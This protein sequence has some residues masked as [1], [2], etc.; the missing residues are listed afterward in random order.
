MERRALLRFPPT[1]ALAV[2]SGEGAEEYAAT[3]HAWRP[4]AEPTSPDSAHSSVSLLAAPRELAAGL[5]ASAVG[6]EV[7]G[8]PSTGFLVRAPDW[9]TLGAALSTAARPPKSRLRIE[10]DPPRL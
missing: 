10:V 4:A 8:G 2:V 9:V 6:V 5:G 3:L 1:A 7:S